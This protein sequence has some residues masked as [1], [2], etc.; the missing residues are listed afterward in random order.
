MI[1]SIP[2]KLSILT[3]ILAI[4]GFGVLLVMTIQYYYSQ[5]MA[6]SA[7]EALFHDISEDVREYM[8]RHD[9]RVSNIFDYLEEFSGIGEKPTA[10]TEHSARKLF[11]K[12]IGNQNSIYAVYA[13]HRDG[14]FYEIINMNLNDSI[15]SVF[16]A[17]ENARWVVIKI[18]GGTGKKLTEFL[19]SEM[20]LISSRIE[21]TDYD[22]VKRPWYIKAD[23]DKDV[24]KTAPYTFS[25]LKEPGVTYA[26]KIGSS[27]VAGV[28]ISIASLSEMLDGQKVYPET[29]IF[30]LSSADGLLAATHNYDR[31]LFFTLLNTDQAADGSLNKLK[32]N[33]Y[34]YITQKVGLNAGHW[35]NDVLIFSIPYSVMASPYLR[36]IKVSFVIT[37]ILSAIVIPLI[38]L[39]TSIIV[40]PLKELMVENE[41][42]RHRKFKDVK[43]IKTIIKEYQ[44]LSKSMVRMSSDIESYQ[45][46]Q[47]KLF[48]SFIRLIAEA[49]DDKSA[50]TGGH[51]ERVPILAEMLTKKA[52]DSDHGQFADFDLKTP[53]E[54][55][56][57]HIG[58]WMHDCGKLTTPEYVVDKST[59]LE[60]IH[61]RIHEIRTRFEVIR[62]DLTIEAYERREKG[63]NPSDVDTWLAGEH[64]KLEEDF[65]FIAEI[66][67]GDTPMQQEHLERLQQIAERE[68]IRNFDSSIGLSHEESRRIKTS[69]PVTPGTENLLADKPE[70]I[71]PRDSSYHKLMEQFDLK[72]N[73]PENLYNLGE[74]HNLS[75]LRGTLTDEERFKIN[76]HVIMTIK[77]LGS[78]PFPDTL[79]KI[80]EYAG[81]HHETLIGTGYPRRLTKEDMSIPARI[82][83]L[84]DVFE[85]LTAADR[86]Y[87]KAKT[88]TESIKILS[89]MVQD[90]HIDRE[91]FELFLTSG[92]YM[93]YAKMFL[94]EEQIDEVDISQYVS[95]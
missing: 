35:E 37:M 53:D 92:I 20:N 72:M 83:A 54:W 60:T 8:I 55:R 43:P 3:N 32:L 87:K 57:L 1:R 28:D 39:S 94:L 7:T 84:A 66:N 49:I 15:K 65:A 70:H 23:N 52:C 14:S 24:V 47:E 64:K 77:M 5:K 90:Q 68:W 27:M 95:Q 41:K 80:P 25:N 91:I 48:D 36:I 59:K 44:D 76:E 40:S 46:A 2:I 12:I 71:I 9:S 17:P 88:L 75:V 93:E 45:M 58:C 21:K 56:E 11:T 79:Q 4:T 81:T 22:P 61:N 38:L 78:L 19:D 69:K 10:G 73:V 62:R 33:S 82:M 6:L 30:L 26:K 16:E 51:C 74:V 67:S 85:A 29:N 86:P 63:E 89:F 13:G 50:Y 31:E 18:T 42:V 34:N